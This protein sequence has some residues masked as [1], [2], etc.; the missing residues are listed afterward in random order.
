M[1]FARWANYGVTA[2]RS[3]KNAARDNLPMAETAPSWLRCQSSFALDAR[4]P[5]SKM[6]PRH[7]Q[8]ALLPRRSQSY[9]SAPRCVM[10]SSPRRWR[11][12]FFSF[13]NWMKDEEIVL[14]EGQ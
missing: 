1:T 14:G 13:I 2:I 7:T 9:Y 8:R 11:S 10:S 3:S 4:G 12:V 6:V 5:D